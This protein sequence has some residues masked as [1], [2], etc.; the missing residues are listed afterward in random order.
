MVQEKAAKQGERNFIGTRIHHGSFSQAKRK[1]APADFLLVHC[2]ESEPHGIV[3]RKDNGFQ[4]A[5][6]HQFQRL[7]GKL[8]IER[9]ARQI[10]LQTG[11]KVAAQAGFRALRVFIVQGR[12][13]GRFG[14]GGASRGKGKRSTAFFLSGSGRGKPGRRGEIGSTYRLCFRRGE[15]CK[16]LVH[17]GAPC[18]DGAAESLVVIRLFIVAAIGG[19]THHR[20]KG[21]DGKG[22]IFFFQ[23]PDQMQA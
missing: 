2:R 13:G 9:P 16:R 7:K 1:D 12:S 18:M 4:N 5:L 20:G 22:G 19:T 10:I 23:F 17:Q 14:R 6:F 8:F 11:F 21:V 3:L 15:A